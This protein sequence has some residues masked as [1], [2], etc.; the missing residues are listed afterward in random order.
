MDQDLRLK[1]HFAAN[2]RNRGFITHIAKNAVG[3]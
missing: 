2:L 3:H 1:P